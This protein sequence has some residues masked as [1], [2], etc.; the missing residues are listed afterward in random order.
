M[1]TTVATGLVG[2]FAVLLLAREW[3]FGGHSRAARAVVLDS[4]A[5]GRSGTTLADVSYLAEGRTVTATLRAWY[6]PLHRGQ[7]IPILYRPSD[8]TNVALD[9]FWQRHFGSMIALAVFAALAAREVLI[10][11]TERRRRSVGLLRDDV[12]S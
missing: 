10:V 12:E 8:P 4:S 1:R 2:I 5:P 11:R 9:W 7:E 3:D 6:C